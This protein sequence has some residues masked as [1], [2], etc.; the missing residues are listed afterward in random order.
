[1]AKKRDTRLKVG[2]DGK[3]RFITVPSGRAAALHFYLRGHRVVAAPPAPSFTG[4]DCI[5]L[6]E[7]RDTTAVQ[8][9]LKAWF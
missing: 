9:L 7:D 6:A 8:E 5:E 1:M 2:V 3:R 4:F